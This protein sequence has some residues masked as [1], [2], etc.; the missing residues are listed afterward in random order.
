MDG[1]DNK[2]DQLI[3]KVDEEENKLEDNDSAEEEDEDDQEDEDHDAGIKDDILRPASTRSKI[4]VNLREPTDGK[5][6]R[7]F[8]DKCE[9]KYDLDRYDKVRMQ[10]LVG[11]EKLYRAYEKTIHEIETKPHLQP[12][13][14]KMPCLQSSFYNLLEA[15][16]LIVVFYVFLLIIQLALFN[17]VIVGIICV[18]MLKLY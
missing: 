5:R 7:Q 18:F 8:S 3:H 12:R 13:K 15:I 16:F 9:I 11:G 14:R 17:L 1:E 10:L 2:R 6:K 4:V